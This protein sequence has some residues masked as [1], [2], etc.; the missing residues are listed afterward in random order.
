MPTGN[1]YLDQES[2]AGA[3]SEDEA[4]SALLR[5][6]SPALLRHLDDQACW[7]FVQACLASGR[8]VPVSKKRSELAAVVLLGAMADFGPS[9]KDPARVFNALIDLSA[10]P[11]VD[12][13]VLFGCKNVIRGLKISSA[14]FL[15]KL[16]AVWGDELFSKGAAR[17][18]GG[19]GRATRGR[20]GCTDIVVIG[21]LYIE[22]W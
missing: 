13:N 20:D 8:T 19:A 15:A 18:G 6:F 7:H 3:A 16:K 12:G 22:Q 4:L 10:L 2:S 5:H 14:D 11:G 17:G 9:F 21:V 1:L